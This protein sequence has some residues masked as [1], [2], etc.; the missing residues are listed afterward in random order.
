MIINITT[1]VMLIVYNVE[2][3]VRESERRVTL[4][5]VSFFFLSFFEYVFAVYSVVSII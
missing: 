1:K 5:S 2:V 4:K 3:V